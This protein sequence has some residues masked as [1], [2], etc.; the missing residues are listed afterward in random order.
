MEA[1]IREVQPLV[2]ESWIRY[3]TDSQQTPLI[4]P[5]AKTEPG[6]KSEGLGGKQAG[7][8][9]NPTPRDSGDTLKLVQEVQDY[10]DTLNIQLSFTIHEKTGDTVVRVLDRESGEVIRQLPPEELLALRDKLDELRGTL[11]D[12]KA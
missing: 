6:A 11:F 9:K 5:V 1:R 12:K 2:A 3:D 10:I 7:K 8:D 4:A